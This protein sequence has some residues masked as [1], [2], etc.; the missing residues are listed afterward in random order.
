M[1]INK[2]YITVVIIAVLFIGVVWADSFANKSEKL[3]KGEALQ[4]NFI[5]IDN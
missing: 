1:K 2:N 5:E 4:E 3:P